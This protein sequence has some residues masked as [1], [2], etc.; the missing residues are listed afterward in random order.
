[1][2]DNDFDKKLNNYIVIKDIE[3]MT[4]KIPLKKPIKMSGLTISFAENLFIKVIDE[5]GFIG[6]GEA[7][8]APT[9][10]GEFS[11]GMFAA[12]IFLKNQLM[13]GHVCCK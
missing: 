9:M 1:M 11:E 8:S 12:A 13:E 6:W 4:M 7:S 3:V 5:N 10:T 2:E